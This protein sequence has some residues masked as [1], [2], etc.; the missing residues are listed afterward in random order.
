MSVQFACNG[1]IEIAY[2]TFGS[3]PGRPLL[4]LHGAGAPML[5]WPEAFCA[6][7]VERGFH[8]ARCDNRDAGRS[9]RATRPYTVADMATDGSSVLDA[10]HW[11]AAHIVGMSL[12]GMIGQ[13]MSAR[14]PDR[15]LSLTSMCSAPDASMWRTKISVLL[16]FLALNCRKPSGPD[17]AGERMVKL[18]QL[19]GSTGYPQDEDWIRRIGREA[20]AHRTDFAAARR[21]AAAARASGNRRAELSTI[22]APTLVLSGD[23]DPL[24]PPR[25]GKATADAIPGAR[26][27]SYPGMGHD[28]PPALWPAIIDD[29]DD[30][31]TTRTG[32]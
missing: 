14:H 19:V 6:A 9:S 13:V 17:A 28:L 4:L 31:A 11:P 20:H 16:R 29:I 22:T 7:L 2:E 26:F 15:V 30:I 23:A 10:L 1:D 18:H 24:Q 3:A 27:V 12:G 5:G 21:Q 8:V 25:A 32:R